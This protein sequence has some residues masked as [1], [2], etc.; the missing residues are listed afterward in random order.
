MTTRL[1]SISLSSPLFAP[2]F[3]HSFF[4]SSHSI[5]IAFAYIQILKLHKVTRCIIDNQNDGDNNKINTTNNK[6]P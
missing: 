1:N 3:F 6:N 2:I 5:L 4:I